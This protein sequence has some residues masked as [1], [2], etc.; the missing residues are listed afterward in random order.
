MACRPP[1]ADMQ[2]CGVSRRH[3]MRPTEQSAL[4]SGPA[5]ELPSITQIQFPVQQRQFP[6]IGVLSVWQ[7][8]R[9]CPAWWSAP[10]LHDRSISLS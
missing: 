1:L 3:H 5:R 10:E 2:A 8:L 7:A 6:R 4:A 9:F